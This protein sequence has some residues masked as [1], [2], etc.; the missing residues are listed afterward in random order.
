MVAF[1]V[2]CVVFFL[3]VCVCVFSL[4]QLVTCH[5]TTNNA[6]TGAHCQTLQVATDRVK[7]RIGSGAA[8]ILAGARGLSRMSEA[9]R[10][11][12]TERAVAAVVAAA[13]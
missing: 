4:A 2:V 12:V 10:R 3:R 5:T 9:A 6:E 11:Q 1:V 7:R 8:D 13:V